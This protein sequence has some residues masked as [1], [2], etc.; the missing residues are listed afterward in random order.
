MANQWTGP[1]PIAERFWPK[2]DVS[3]PLG[4][5]EWIAYVNPKGYGDFNVSGRPVHAHR[6]AYELLRGPIPDGLHLDHLCRNTSCVNPDHLE[7]VTPADNALR[8]FGVLAKHA[9]K[10]TCARGHVFTAENTSLTKL[11]RRCRTCHRQNEKERRDR[12][13][14]TMRGAA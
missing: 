3:H 13:K 14:Q 2:V 4:C 9:R 12:R 11:G 10:T 6:V 7:A 5:W 1:A 8:G